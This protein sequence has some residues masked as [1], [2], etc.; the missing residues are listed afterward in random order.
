MNEQRLDR[1]EDMLTTLII[2]VG[3]LNHQF[4]EMKIEQQEMK[5]EQQE[6]KRDIQEVK[7]EQKEMKNEQSIMRS[8]NEKQF[9]EIQK[10]LM[11]IRIDQDHIWEKVVRN[12]RELAKLKGHLQL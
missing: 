7:I 8:E 5:K 9:S 2:M 6:M 1:M 10:T 4:Q 11:D 12:E 3:D